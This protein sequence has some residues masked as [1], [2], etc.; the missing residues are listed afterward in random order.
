MMHVTKKKMPCWLSFLQ[1]NLML[2]PHSV[3][4][5][6]GDDINANKIIQLI[7]GEKEIR[8][9]DSLYMVRYMVLIKRYVVL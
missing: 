3:L 6:F 7:F 2:H 5:S 4:P 1:K 8:I 9:S